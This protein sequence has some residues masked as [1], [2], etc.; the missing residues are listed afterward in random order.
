MNFKYKAKTVDGNNVEGEIEAANEQLAAEALTGRG[1]ILLSLFEQKTTSLTTSLR[2]PFLNRIKPEDMLL[3]SRQLSVMISAGLPLVRALE[4]L[5]KQTSNRI[6]KQMVSEIADD[7]RGGARFSSALARHPKVFDDFFINMVRAGE[8]SGRFDEV[9]NYL[10]DEQEKNYDLMSK[11]KGAMIYPAFILVAVGAVMFIM[12]TFVVPKLVAVLTEAGVTLPLPT[13]ILIFVANIFSNFWVFLIIFL[14]LVIVVIQFLI[15]KSKAG[16]FLWD[17]LQL[18]L[19]VIGDL[20]QK[21]YIVRMAR[22]LSTLLNGGVPLN[23][24]L[25]IVSDVIGN[26]F[27]RDLVLQ[28]VKV[29]EDGYS[30]STVFAKYKEVPQMLSQIMIV[31]EQTGRLDSIL[32]RLA[33]FYAR[34]VENILA[35]LTTLLEPMIIVFLGVVVAGMVAA[36]IMPMYNLAS[37]IK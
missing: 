2:L 10:A 13:R 6:L 22:S 32:D 27:Y 5:H 31:G 7:V 19:P 12:M 20:F 18:K 30:V 17:F 15:H 9:L 33:S 24:A 14:I 37:A 36:I 25:K 28:T 8:T 4:V 21:I 35:R 23:S 11:V 16:R 29:V 1:L 26:A 3:F 34:E